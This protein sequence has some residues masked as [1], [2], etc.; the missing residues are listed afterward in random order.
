M[1]A[2]SV[3]KL[4]R[5]L[6]TFWIAES[7]VFTVSQTEVFLLSTINKISKSFTPLFIPV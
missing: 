4:S 6:L 7:L 5:W 3:I 2:D 1:N